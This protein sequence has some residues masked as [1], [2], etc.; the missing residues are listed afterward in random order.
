MS[1]WYLINHHLKFSNTIACRIQALGAEIFSP[2]KLAII[3]RTDCNGVRQRQSQLFPGYLFVKLDPEIVHTSAILQINGVNDFVR[4]GGALATISNEMIDSLKSSLLI[5]ADRPVA[6]IEYRNVH[7]AL[8]ASFE[9]IMLMK[10]KIDRQVALF[11][12]LQ[13]EKRILDS[14]SSS[15]ILSIIERPFVNDLIK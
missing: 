12:L 11:Q 14:S 15:L 9:A 13:D 1:S 5:R 7:P 8:L 10:S 2:I 4:F 3:N 6:Q